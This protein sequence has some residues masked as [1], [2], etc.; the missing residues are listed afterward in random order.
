MYIKTKKNGGRPFVGAVSILG[1]S[2]SKPTIRRALLRYMKKF[3]GN[4]VYKKYFSTLALK[5]LE[6]NKLFGKN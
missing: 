4:K 5:E 3:Y 6:N 2:E 1:G